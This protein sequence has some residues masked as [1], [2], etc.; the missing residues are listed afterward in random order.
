MKISPDALAELFQQMDL[1]GSIPRAVLTELA[2]HSKIRRV[3]AGE[4]VFH[5]NDTG[6]ALFMILEGSVKVH[7]DDYVVAQQFVGSFF[8]ELALLDEGPR[9]MSIS[10]TTDTL[11][12]VIERTE[13][14]GVLKDY[15][16]VMQTVVGM[17]TRRLRMQ[18]DKL[19][20]QL[21]RREEELTRLVEERTA[22]VM[23]QKEEAERQR[24]Q[25]E[26]EKKEAQFQRQRA[27]Q[28]ERIKQQF[29]A[30][31]SHE[32]RT[33]MNAIIGL[34]HLLR[35]TGPTPE[36]ADRLSKIHNAARHLLNLINDI[37]DLATIE[38]GKLELEQTV[39]SPEAIL[40]SVRSMIADQAQ[41]KG[42]TLTV[43]GAGVPRWLRGDPTRLRQ[44]LLNYAQNAVTFT[45]QGSITVGVRLLADHGDELLVRFEVRD[46]GIGIAAEQ[47]PKLFTAFEQVDSSSTRRYSGAGLGLAISR[48]L[49]RLM[50][51]DAGA[52]SEPGVGSTFWFTAR[53][54]RSH[55]LPPAASP[56]KTEVAQAELRQRHAGA[57]LLLAEDNAINREVLLK[58]LDRA[59]LA[60][61]IAK[62]GR[63]AVEKVRSGAYALV[64]MD[65]QMPVMD[66]LAATR[67]IRQLPGAMALPILA[68]TA[69]ASDT[70]R[71]HCLDAG[72]DD[73]LT[74][75]VKPD[76]LYA[77]LLRWLPVSGPPAPVTVANPQA[78]ETLAHLE[79]LLAEDDTRASQIW[80]EAAPV[81]TAML[82]TAAIELGQAIACFEYDK[83]LR[84]LRAALAALAAIQTPGGI[85]HLPF[86]WPEEP[87]QAAS[88]PPAAPPIV[89]HILSHPWH[90]PRLLRREVPA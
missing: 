57:R 73:F 44:A 20:E 45:E 89:K 9:S 2:A 51:G 49:A 46:T 54:Q 58:L 68:L 37:L 61:D 13:F 30:N 24:A 59:G 40:E 38:A 53:L 29:L 69:S 15:P 56:T 63:E 85:L 84:M 36:Q 66:G 79:A 87:K 75:P 47:L 27:E 23:R 62:D 74:K 70:D 25:A 65:V 60:L 21:R 14:Y 10:A 22:E 7:D 3:S 88:E 82:G 4:T 18:T 90:L 64:L 28:S 55:D 33:P 50:G 41:T 16:A 11:L 19:V 81:A 78:R 34:T 76:T 43:N 83:A 6:D 71:Q 32:I 48:R 35:Q 80:H 17:L 67:A 26:A 52:D 31:M 8:G 77:T 12:A 86:E 1:F 72:M 42:L 39:F 5:K